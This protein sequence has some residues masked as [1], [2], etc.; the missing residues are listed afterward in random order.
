MYN[1]NYYR[2]YRTI[3]RGLLH[4]CKTMFTAGLVTMFYNKRK[5]Q[6]MN[7]TDTHKLKR[8]WIVA[9]MILSWALCLI[10]VNYPDDHVLPFSPILMYVVYSI[11]AAFS[12][13]SLI[14]FLIRKYYLAD[15]LAIAVQASYFILFGILFVKRLL[16]DYVMFFPL[17]TISLFVMFVLALTTAVFLIITIKRQGYLLSIITY[18]LFLM[19]VIFES[20]PV[21][22]EQV[23]EVYGNIKLIYFVAIITAS[24]LG[25]IHS[26]QSYKEVK[27]NHL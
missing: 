7:K 14:M 4:V 19:C 18:S 26:I 12:I 16:I 6:S 13:T 8:L 17:M 20:Y 21:A 22:Y 23:S 15:G 5:I 9:L 25:I 24:I 10:T 1:H 11:M 27:E 2:T 3:I